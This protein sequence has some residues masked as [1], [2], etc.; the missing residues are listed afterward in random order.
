MVTMTI[1]PIV[2]GILLIITAVF[3]LIIIAW[4]F[5]E[6]LIHG[7][8]VWDGLFVFIK[9]WFIVFGLFG[10]ANSIQRNNFRQSLLGASLLIVGVGLTTIIYT[11]L[12]SLVSITYASIITFIMVIVSIVLIATSKNEFSNR[13]T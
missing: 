4:Q 6:L 12:P 11:N 8:N 3:F 10:A 7:L 5:F 9:G 2:A 1:K 13:H